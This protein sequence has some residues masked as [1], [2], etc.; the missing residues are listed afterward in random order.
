[1]PSWIPRTEA[2]RLIWLQNYALKLN[3]HVGTAGI[4]AG[5]VTTTNNQRDTFEW[6]INRSDQINTVRQDLNEWKR[7][8]ADGPIGTPLG[9]PPVAPLYPLPPPLFTPTAGMF[10]QVVAL[11]ER[12][13]NTAGYTT[14]IGEDLGIVPPA[15]GAPVLG[16]PTFTALALPNSEVRLNWVKGSSDGVI[17]ESQRAAETTWTS[18][19]TDRFSPFV[20]GRAPLL[21]GQPEVRRYRIRYLDGDDPIGNYSA[22]VSVTTVP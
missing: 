2:D 17:V 19:G 4:T 12:I 3:V 22:T 5:D 6:I 15:P 9:D 8:F 18:L 11:A 14:A 10:D 21:P 7:I 13:R 20:D 16:D 1:M